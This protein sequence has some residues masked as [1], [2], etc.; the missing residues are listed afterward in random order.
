MVFRL[1]FTFTT[2]QATLAREQNVKYCPK[3]DRACD[4]AMKNV[5]MHGPYLHSQTV[6]S[7]HPELLIC[8]YISRITF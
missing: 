6:S 3:S 8:N 1:V 4:L 5:E 7:G 2:F